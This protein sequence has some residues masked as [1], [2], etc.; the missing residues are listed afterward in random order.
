[1]SEL[2]KEKFKILALDGGG[3]R[4]VVTARILQSIQEQIGQPLNQYFDL[5]AGTSTGSIL[6]AGIVLGKKPQQLVDIYKSRGK[7]IF[8]ASWLRKNITRFVFGS[9]Y[10]NV[11]LIRVL[12]EYLSD[13][14]SLSEA[15]NKSK[16][17]LLILA[18]DTL[19]R[20]T[21]FFT[22]RSPEQNRWFNQMKLWE[23]C[24]SSASAP[25]FFPPY[26]FRW[27]DP[28][29]P[30]KTEWKFPHVDGGVSANCPALSALTYATNVRNVN[31][32]NISVLSIGTG[33]TTQPLEYQQI[34]KW[35]TAIWGLHV[36]D[37]FMGG[38]LQLATD[39]CQE[40]IQ[41]ANPEGYIRL[42]FNLNERF[43]K[44]TGEYSS[45][46]LLPVEAQ[47]NKYIDAK[48]NEEMDDAS[49][50]NIS[51]LIHATDIFMQSKIDSV[52][53]FLKS[54]SSCL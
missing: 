22:S 6:A 28:N 40:I 36:S 31:I 21:T 17:E 45:R 49:D 24:A 13:E 33:R 5:I 4:G 26:E 9:K 30:Q 7:E 53:N 27:I 25:T 11:G 15:S 16:A 54:N 32:E 35:G 51:K 34:S 12:K 8:H 46:P 14:L 20:N 50:D 47:K 10:S 38:Q 29:D 43:G 19:Y 23:V 1:M 42:Q 3:I 2:N 48:I 52:N 37:V 18:Y 41:T 44:Q 39:L